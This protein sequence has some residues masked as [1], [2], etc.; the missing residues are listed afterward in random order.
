VVLVEGNYLLLDAA[1]WSGLAP[2]FDL[3][4]MTECPAAAVAARLRARW[5]GFGLPEAEVARRLEANDLPNARLVLAQSVE[6]D[7]RLDTG[8]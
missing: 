2:L 1:P 3:R 7:L 6:P 5:E 4:V 8:A